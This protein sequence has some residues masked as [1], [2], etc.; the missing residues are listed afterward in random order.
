MRFGSYKQFY[1]CLISAHQTSHL[2]TFALNKSHK[3]LAVKAIDCAFGVQPKDVRHALEKGDPIPRGR[4]EHSG[5]EEDIEQQL[6]DWITKNAQNHT[7]IN[8][9][10]LLHYCRET[11]GGAVTAG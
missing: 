4:G 11:F 6:I 2:H 10:E 8:R 1:E 7:V 9:T 5:L 3:R